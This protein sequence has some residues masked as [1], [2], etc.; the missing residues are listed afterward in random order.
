MHYCIHRRPSVVPSSGTEERSP[1]P[2][3]LKIRFH[4]I[5]P[6]TPHFP[7]VS[8]F[9]DFPTATLFA[10]IAI[11]FPSHVYLMDL[12]FFSTSDHVMLNGG[13]INY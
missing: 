4:I 11:P 5:R 13:R 1:H 8:I 12:L 2:I 3:Y 9:S 10:F 6:L 7:G